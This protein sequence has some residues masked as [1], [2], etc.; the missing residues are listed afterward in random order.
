MASKT[1]SE[2]GRW[3]HPGEEI[4]WPN[5]RGGVFLRHDESIG[6][7]RDAHGDQVSFIGWFAR[8]GKFNNQATIIPP[9]EATHVLSLKVKELLQ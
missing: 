4:R 7:Y 5:G 3:P 2:A 8:E 6:W 9:A 1:M